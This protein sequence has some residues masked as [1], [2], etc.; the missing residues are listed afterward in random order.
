MADPDP[1]IRGALPYIRHWLLLDTGC[2]RRQITKKEHDMMNPSRDTNRARV[3]TW[4][5]KWAICL[6]LETILI[7]FE[8]IF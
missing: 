3:K 1:E 7:L 8:T 2:E 4:P 6:V 5:T